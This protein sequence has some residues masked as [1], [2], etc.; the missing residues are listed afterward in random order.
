MNAQE[1][2]GMMKQRTANLALLLLAVGVA[3]SLIACGGGSSSPP[4][5]GSSSPPPL[6]FTATGSM[7]TARAGHTA[8]P[9]AN[10]KVLS[11]GGDNFGNS[12][13]TAELFDPASGSFSATGSM[14]TPREIHAT[15]LLLSGKVLILGGEVCT[16]DRKSVV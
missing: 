14:G 4:P 5:A 3:F 15:V 6:G 11:I 7:Q 2:F 16:Q 10:G 12:L 1:L 9:L 8:T 13:A